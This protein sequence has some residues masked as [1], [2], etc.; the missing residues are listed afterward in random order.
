MFDFLLNLCGWALLVGTFFLCLKLVQFILFIIVALYG[1]EYLHI[2]MLDYFKAR[3]DDAVHL[4]FRKVREKI[5]LLAWRGLQLIPEIRDQDMAKALQ[6]ILEDARRDV[7]RSGLLDVSL[8][9]VNAEL[10]KAKSESASQKVSQFLKEWNQLCLVLP[11]ILRYLAPSS[12]KSSIQRR[13]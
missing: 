10:L 5:S 12:S 7:S 4:V 9:V 6:T 13:N 11:L 1:L 8:S 3:D 2:D